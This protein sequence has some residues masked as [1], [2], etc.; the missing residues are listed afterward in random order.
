MP[1]LTP[2]DEGFEIFEK[3][4]NIFGSSGSE[5]NE[6]AVFFGASIV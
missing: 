2:I 1:A 6:T 3:N 4:K 5:E